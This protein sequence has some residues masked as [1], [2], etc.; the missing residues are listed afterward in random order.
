MLIP[1]DTNTCQDIQFQMMDS[2]LFLHDIGKSSRLE[3]LLICLWNFAGWLRNERVA[4]RTLIVTMSAEFFLLEASVS[5][6]LKLSDI[7]VAFRTS[8]AGRLNVSPWCQR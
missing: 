4:L 8:E 2:A 3:V 6:S 5:S 1:L 7:E